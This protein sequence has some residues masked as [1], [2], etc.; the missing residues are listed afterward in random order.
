MTDRTETGVRAAIEDLMN[1]AIL[2]EA[3]GLDRIYHNDM[4]ILMLDISGELARFDKTGFMALMAN[5]VKDTN[6]DDHKW[7]RFNAVEANGDQG[8]VLIT[9]RVPIG[10]TRKVLE[11]SIDLIFE[12]GRWQVTREV[13]FAH[14][15]PDP[16]SGHLSTKRNALCE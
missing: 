8:H 9:R 10:D 6:P 14:P 13:I 3:K 5:S 4:Q 11:L 1:V 2:G 16:I 15:D 7:A 12:D